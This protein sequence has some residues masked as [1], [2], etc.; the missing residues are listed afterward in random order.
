[1]QT[2]FE[3]DFNFIIVLFAHF[4]KQL[5]KVFNKYILQKLS[6]VALA[7]HLINQMRNQKSLIQYFCDVAV[8]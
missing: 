6:L 5:I 3:I 4:H 8:N 7:K 1:M 2:T